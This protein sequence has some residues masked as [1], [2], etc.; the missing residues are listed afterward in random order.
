MCFS[1]CFGFTEQ[2]HVQEAASGMLEVSLRF[3]IIA[4]T[5]KLFVSLS[6]CSRYRKK[7]GKIPV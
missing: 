6:L 4:P 5:W 2:K 7:S 3:F 1:V